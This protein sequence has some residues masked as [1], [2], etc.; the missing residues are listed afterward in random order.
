MG[1]ALNEAFQKGNATLPQGLAFGTDNTQREAK[2]QK[3]HRVLIILVLKRVFRWVLHGLLRPGHTHN[4]LDGAFGTTSGHIAREHFDDPDELIDII[5]RVFQNMH[6]D[7][8]L[9]TEAYKLDQIADWESWADHLNL[10]ITNITG[11]GSCHY[12][13]YCRRQDLGQPFL[14]HGHSY[15]EEAMTPV[16]DFAPDVPR[17]ADDVMCVVKAYLSSRKVLQIKAVCP[18]SR[19]GAVPECPTGLRPRKPVPDKIK[20][21]IEKHA[22]EAMQRGFITANACSYLLGWVRNDLALQPRSTFPFLGHRFT[23]EPEPVAGRP[24][25]LPKPTKRMQIKIKPL[26]GL[27]GPDLQCIQNADIEDTDPADCG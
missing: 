7:C 5:G 11:P 2:N 13:R 4:G 1:R 18:A 26:P 14:D 22:P 25:I 6:T 24:D 10:N 21:D 19:A 16:E 3:C 15:S 20:D 9:K 12:F 23:S 27:V 8:P 17:H